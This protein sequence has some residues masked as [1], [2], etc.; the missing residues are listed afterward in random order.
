M[1]KIYAPAGSGQ[2]G[3]VLDVLSEDWRS[4]R[5]VAGRQLL[6]YRQGRIECVVCGQRRRLQVGGDRRVAVIVPLTAVL[7][8]V[9]LGMLMIALLVQL[10]L[11]VMP[12]VGNGVGALLTGQRHQGLRCRKLGLHSHDHQ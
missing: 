6:R 7:V 11:G 9:L 4:K 12:L 1:V 5:L 3:A 2:T 8:F 10:V